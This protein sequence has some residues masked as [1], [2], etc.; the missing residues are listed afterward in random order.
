MMYEEVVIY[1]HQIEVKLQQLLSKKTQLSP[2]GPISLLVGAT[3][4]VFSSYIHYTY[5]I[6]NKTR[7]KV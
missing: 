5:S 1:A 2:N 7:L 6:L 3:Y 4:T